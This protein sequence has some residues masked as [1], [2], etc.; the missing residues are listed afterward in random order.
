MNEL[1]TYRVDWLNHSIGFLSALL[2]IFIA[3]RLENYRDNINEQERIE[4][5]K[6]ALKKEIQNNL[7]IYKTTVDDLTGW[8]EYSEFFYK[9]LNDRFELVVG[10][11]EMSIMSKK[12]PS[13]FAGLKHL[14]SINDTLNAYRCNFLFDVTPTTG[15][16]TSNWKAAV[17]SG[18]L[19]SMDYS[20]TS[21]LSQI[22]DW[23]D[24][25]IGVSEKELYEIHLA[26]NSIDPLT[27][28]KKTRE[29]YSS[30]TKVYSFKY[31]IISEIL[32]KTNWDN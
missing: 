29:H 24:K 26:I 15:V 32:S 8:L 18:T 12:Y 14:R 9:K 7:K 21:N 16:S 2:G 23:T 13:R 6:Q 3:F 10:V 27:I 20:L 17:G 22:Y 31:R 5:V 30:L 11:N 4:I 19:S 25:E 1:N 28:N